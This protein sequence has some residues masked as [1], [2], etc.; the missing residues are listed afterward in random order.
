MTVELRNLTATKLHAAL[1][2]TKVPSDRSIADTPTAAAATKSYTMPLVCKRSGI[3]VGSLSVATVA[4]HM[5]MIGQWKE[6]MVLHPLFSLTPVA[7]LQ[8]SRNSW[9]RF[10]SFS[11]E[12]GAD[13]ALTAK[14]EQTLRVA[15]LAMLHHLANVRQDIAWLPDWASVSA[16][17]SS[18]MA[19]SYWKATLD[20]ERFRFPAIHLSR[21]EPEIELK[22]YL[23]SC[24]QV[25][26]DYETRVS[27]RVEQERL[28]AADSAIIALRDEI[29]GVRPTSSRQLWRWFLAHLPKRYEAD[30]EGWMRTLFFAKGDD[31]R[32]FTLADIDLFEEIFLCEVPTGSSIS[33]AFS[34]VLASKRKILEQH[35]ETFEILIPEAITQAKA[36]GEIPVAEPKKEDFTSKVS[37]MIA[38]AKWRL[39]HTD[40]GKSINRVTAAQSR[41]TVNPSY[42]PQLTIYEQEEAAETVLTKEEAGLD[43]GINEQVDEAAHD[44]DDG[45]NY[46]D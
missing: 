27:E 46:E 7:L 15:A 43:V 30:S 10:C 31:V 23:Q 2:A 38:H 24:W 42:V 29:A 4:G 20:S 5:P 21:L 34:E 35:I 39:A 40:M 28:R 3:T 8:F 41:V 16:H 32:K 26:K 45:G 25:K 14:Q 33:H 22:A 12:E 17:W 37:F 11:V 1:A 9:F 18:L 36:A 6:T 19:L 44:I 13:D